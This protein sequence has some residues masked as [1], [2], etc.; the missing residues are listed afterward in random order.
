MRWPTCDNEVSFQSCLEQEEAHTLI[1]A[2]TEVAKKL[3]RKQSKIS[4]LVERAERWRMS[5]AGMR[6]TAFV[7]RRQW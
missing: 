6:A 3:A 7:L 5:L 1:V 2:M 4:D